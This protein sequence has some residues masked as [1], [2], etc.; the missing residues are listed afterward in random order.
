MPRQLT[1]DNLAKTVFPPSGIDF[2]KISDEEAAQKY[3]ILH[4]PALVYFRKRLPI[5]YEGMH[6]LKEW[7]C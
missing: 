5:I 6:H 3:H 2:V 7:P 4:T 1:V